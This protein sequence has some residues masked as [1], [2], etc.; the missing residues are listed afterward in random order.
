MNTLETIVKRLVAFEARPPK[1]SPYEAL[2]ADAVNGTPGP[3]Y[4]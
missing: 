4:E 3:R 2:K 1:P